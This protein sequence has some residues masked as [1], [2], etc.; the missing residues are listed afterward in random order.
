MVFP[1][2]ENDSRSDGQDW[3]RPSFCIAG[4]FSRYHVT[5]VYS[6][7]RGQEKPCDKNMERDR[8]T[9]IHGTLSARETRWTRPL[10]TIRHANEWMT[11]N[12]EAEAR[13]SVTSTPRYYNLRPCPSITSVASVIASEREIGTLEKIHSHSSWI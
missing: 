12:T 11:R 13:E 1:R 4:A 10:M 6:N 3:N 2:E 8:G 9:K 5:R 7:A